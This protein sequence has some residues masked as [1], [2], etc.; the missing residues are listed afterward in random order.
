M[1]MGGKVDERTTIKK[2]KIDFQIINKTTGEAGPHVLIWCT[3]PS[4]LSENSNLGKVFYTA[5]PAEE[6]G[7][8][9]SATQMIGGEIAGMILP[10][11]SVDDSGK[12]KY[13][14]LAWDTVAPWT[15]EADDGDLWA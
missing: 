2:T 1:G 10:S 14:N 7:P 6:I 3:W 9:V 5:V 15:A 11:E 8:S 12:A 4:R 13:A